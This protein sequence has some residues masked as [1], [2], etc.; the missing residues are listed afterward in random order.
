MRI[1][2]ISDDFLFWDFLNQFFNFWISDFFGFFFPFGVRFSFSPLTVSLWFEWA[3]RN[4]PQNSTYVNRHRKS[5]L[6]K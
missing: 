4:Q 3:V 2:F 1:G 6:N 5:Y